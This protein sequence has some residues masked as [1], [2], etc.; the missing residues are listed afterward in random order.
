MVLF[1][2]FFIVIR[3]FLGI[4]KQE[5]WTNHNLLFINNYCL[6]LSALS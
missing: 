6:G 5:I 4:S 3:D 1:T 2:F